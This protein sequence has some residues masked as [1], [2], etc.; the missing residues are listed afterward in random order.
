MKKIKLISSNIYASLLVSIGWLLGALGG[1]SGGNKAY[2]RFALPLLITGLAYLD[3]ESILVLT[4][5]S[6]CGIY[7]IGYGLPG[8]NDPKPSQLGAFFFNLCHQNIFWANTLTRTVIGLLVCLSLISIPIIR[9]NWG[10]Y[11]LCS[12]GIIL[13]WA[14][15]SWKDLGTYYLGKIPLLWSEFILYGLITI[16]SIIMIKLGGIHG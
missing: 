11:G 9:H 4:I 8:P 3:T 7:S 16:F 13:V 12:L 6:M 2:R 14:L 5:L 15:I 1:S 10:V